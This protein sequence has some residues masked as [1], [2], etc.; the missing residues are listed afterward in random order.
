[1]EVEKNHIPLYLEL[2]W[3]LKDMI[4]SHEFPLGAQMPSIDE[5]HDQWSVS[6]GT[7]SKAMELLEREGLVV[8]KRGAGTF[9]R[10]DVDMVMWDPTTSDEEIW[11]AMRVNRIELIAD[12]WIE[13]PTRMQTIFADEQDAF[14]KGQ[15]YN[16]RVLSIHQDNEWKKNLVDAYLPAWVLKEVTPK[17]LR[18]QWVHRGLMM[19]KNHKTLRI[20][21]TLRPAICNRETAARLGLPPG[22]FIFRKQWTYYLEDRR[23]LASLDILTTTNAL[24]RDI[25]VRW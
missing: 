9:V 12:G 17:Q 3:Q 6:Q 2:Y 7:V 20:K 11:S 13:A 16:I 22:S 4:L 15:L 19:I 14:K 18:E 25:D 8:R 21:Q 5:L 1:M 23:I 10:E 24:V